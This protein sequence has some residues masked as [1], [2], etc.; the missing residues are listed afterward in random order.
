MKKVFLTLCSIALVLTMCSCSFKVM[1]DTIYIPREKVTSAAIQLEYK[2]EGKDSYYCQKEI[3]DS[4]DLDEICAMIRK[5]PATKASSEH[6]NPIEEATIIVILRGQ[7][8]HRL[9]MNEQM[10]FFDQVAYEYTKDN[11]FERFLDFYNSIGYPEEK[12]EPS[13]Y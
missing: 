12:A 1:D 6:P 4:A 10:A 3:T 7:K 8:E 2:E 13:Y 9:I 5:L 11:A